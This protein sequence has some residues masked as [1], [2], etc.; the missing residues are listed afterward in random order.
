MYHQPPEKLAEPASKEKIFLISKMGI[1]KRQKNE[2][3]YLVTQPQIC[4]CRLPI[5]KLVF[6]EVDNTVICPFT[7]H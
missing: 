6:Q 5:A 7:I 2:K 3:R 4:V 1:D